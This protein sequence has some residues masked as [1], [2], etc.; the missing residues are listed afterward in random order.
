MNLLEK[1]RRQKVTSTM[2]VVLT[3]M[4]GI[5]IGTL[6]NTRWGSAVAQSRATDATPLVVP[7]AVAIGNEFSQ[8]AK[9]LEASVVNISVEIKTP[10]GGGLDRTIPPAVGPPR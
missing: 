7:P 3:L 6:V 1:L 9:K 4:V 5:L 8:L 10:A 2:V